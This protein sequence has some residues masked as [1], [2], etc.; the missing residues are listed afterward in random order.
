[1][2]CEVEGPLDKPRNRVSGPLNKPRNILTEPLHKQ[3]NIV[4][5]PLDCLHKQRNIVTSNT[6]TEWRNHFKAHACGWCRRGFRRFDSFACTHNTLTDQNTQSIIFSVVCGSLHHEKY[7]LRFDSGTVFRLP[8][9]P[10]RPRRKNCLMKYQFTWSSLIVLC[11]WNM[12]TA[13]T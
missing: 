2:V 6:E 12:G 9:E 8:P 4:T 5:E 11:N 3:W 1:M 10:G 13:F 7:G